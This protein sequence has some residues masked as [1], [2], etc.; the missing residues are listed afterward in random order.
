MSW[1][2]WELPFG[3]SDL[4]TARLRREC[5]EILA[6]LP[7]DITEAEAKAELEPTVREACQEFSKRKADQERQARKTRL[8]EQGISQ[9]C[10]YLLELKSQGEVTDAEFWNSKFTDE[11]KD[12]VHSRLEAKLTGDESEKELH[13]LLKAAVNRQLT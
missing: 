3:K 10:S 11:I 1:A 9:V 12:G 5:A 13:K 8:V 7:D 4:D 2:V 6:E